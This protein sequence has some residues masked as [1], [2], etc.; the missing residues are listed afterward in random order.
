MCHQSSGPHA[1]IGIG[2][3][4]SLDDFYEAET[5][6]CIGQSRNQSSPDV[7]GLE[8]AVKNGARIVAVNPLRRLA[9]SGF[10]H[11]QK[12][13]GLRTRRPHSPLIPSVK[14]NGDFALLRALGKELFHREKAKPGTVIDTRFITQNTRD[15]EAYRAICEVSSWK[16]LT[17]KCS[18]SR[19][20]IGELVDTILRGKRRLITCW[21]MGLTQHRNAVATIREIA[22]LH[23]LLGAIGRPGAGLCPVRGHSNVQGDRT[24]GIFEKMPEAFLAALDREFGITCPR[25]HGHDTVNA[26]LSMHQ[27]SGQVFVALN[28]SLLLACLQMGSA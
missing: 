28:R 3:T 8:T 14:I 10:A 22:N 13:S 11:P 27:K 4:V 7:V 25:D 6:L 15:F 23:L 2:G 24:M 5:I 19:E 17:D 12:I 16:E 20:E 26:I 1:S 21:A 18:I 9:F